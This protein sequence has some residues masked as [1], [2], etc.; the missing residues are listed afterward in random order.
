[1]RTLHTQN[2][3]TNHRITLKDSGN[4]L[5][6][7]PYSFTTPIAVPKTFYPKIFKKWPLRLID[8]KFPISVLAPAAHYLLSFAV[9][10]ALHSHNHSQLGVVLDQL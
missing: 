7:L 6:P 4:L 3:F 8:L 9:V 2:D 1:M 5:R 10:R